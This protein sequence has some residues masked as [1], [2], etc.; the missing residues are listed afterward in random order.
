MTY[1]SSDTQALVKRS[2]PQDVL[3]VGFG[4]IWLIDAVLKWLPGFR[5]TYVSA[6]TGAAQG[7]P[8]WLRWWF[9]FWVKLQQPRP[10]LFAYVV[11]VLETLVAVAIITGFARKYTYIASAV[12]GVVIW[13]VAEGFGGPYGQGSSD[14]G[15]AIIYTLV[16][17][18]MLTLCYYV[19]A[20]RYSVDFY[21]EKR[22]SWWWKVAEMHRPEPEEVT[23]AGVA[24]NSSESIVPVVSPGPGIALAPFVVTEPAATVGFWGLIIW[25]VLAL[26]KIHR[27]I[28][29]LHDD[30]ARQIL[31]RRLARGEL[32]AEEYR[33]VVE[34]LTHDMRV[35]ASVGVSHDNY[36]R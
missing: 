9:D 33:R 19:G 4:L 21:L 16:S 23:L 8:G 26:A 6:V 11:A 25:A 3:R 17:I 14:I 10:T 7:Q 27:A 1:A 2:W 24:V 30:D 35:D 34:T 20:S 18:G 22:F 31:D 28:H 15:T 13:A 32:D 5:S 36:P 29:Q 12:F